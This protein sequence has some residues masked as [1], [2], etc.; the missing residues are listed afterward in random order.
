[1]RFLRQM[2]RS[3]VPVED[4][5]TEEDRND[6]AVSITGLLLCAFID[7][8]VEVLEDPGSRLEPSCLSRFDGE[9]NPVHDD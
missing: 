3:V 8:I 1:M 6:P 4:P 5:G 9:P 7:A 2:H